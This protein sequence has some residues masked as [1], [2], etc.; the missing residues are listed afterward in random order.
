[1]SDVLYERTGAIATVTLNR[2]ERMNTISHPMLLA[3]SDALITASRDREVRAIV[4]TGA[5]RAFC[6]GLICRMPRARKES[7]RAVSSSRLRSTCA[8]SRRSCCM[9]STS[10]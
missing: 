6:A 5:G 3:L 4:I 2:P 9:N 1:M 8:I 7:P 10:R